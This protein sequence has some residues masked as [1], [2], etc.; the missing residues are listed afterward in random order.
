MTADSEPRQTVAEASD[1][2]RGASPTPSV[3]LSYARVD[4]EDGFVKSVY[5]LLKE[6][7]FNVWWDKACM[8]SRALTFL[9]EIAEA[10]GAADRL[11]LIV[12]PNA[13]SSE[14]VRAEWQYAL[15]ADKVVTPVLRAG[16]FDLLPAELR[17]THCEDVRA[18][19][20]PNEALSAILRLA[21]DPAPRL[22]R[23]FAV[24]VPPAHY[25]P[26]PADFAR[27]AERLM[28]DV[29]EQLAVP[30]EKRAFLIHGMGGVGKSV[31][32]A[33]VA[34]STATR[35]VFSDDVVW[36]AAGPDSGTLQI[37]QQTGSAAG[38]DIRQ[39]AN[40]DAA[41]E[42]LRKRLER[43]AV[44]I[45]LDNIWSKAPV[46]AIREALG[47]RCR[48]IVTTREPGLAVLG[49]PAVDVSPFS[50]EEAVA[51][52]EERARADNL[53]L[54]PAIAEV[55]KECG[56]LPFALTLAGAMA[57]STSWETLA[58]RLRAADLSFMEAN[59]PGYPYTNLLR[60]MQV[61]VDWLGSSDDPDRRA[62]LARYF[63]IAAFR[64][65]S[66]VPEAALATLWR[67]RGGIDAAVSGRMLTI[68]SRYGLVRTEGQSPRRLVRV[69]DL[70]Q[71]YL[72]ARVK[73][74]LAE[75]AAILDAYA[76]MDAAAP[77]VARDD[78]YYLDNVFH[79]LEKAEQ[80]DRMHKVLTSNAADGR[81][82]WWCTR[83]AHGQA[84]GFVAD[85][86]RGWEHA[87]RSTLESGAPD[88]EAVV[89]AAQYALMI[90]SARV[91]VSDVPVGFVGR[92]L[93]EKIW[94]GE[95]AMAV[96]EWVARGQ[97]VL[98]A[99]VTVLPYLPS[100]RKQDAIE[101]GLRMARD[102]VE[103]PDRAGSLL[104]MAPFLDDKQRGQVV[105][106]ALELIGDGASYHFY[107]QAH[108]VA[109]E[110]KELLERAIAAAQSAGDGF[111]RKMA[112]I[113]LA[114]VV[115]EDRIGDLLILAYGA[116]TPE[117]QA[118]VLLEL[119]ARLPEQRRE[120]IAKQAFAL[121][122][123]GEDFK[124]AGVTAVKERARAV[125]LLP[126]RERGR[127][128][129]GIIN[130]LERLKW[131][132]YRL[133]ALADIVPFLDGTQRTEAE[134]L[135]YELSG[136]L[137]GSDIADFLGES[138]RGAWLAKEVP[139][140]FQP[141]VS[142]LLK[143][144]RKEDKAYTRTSALSAL[145]PFVD[146]AQVRALFEEEER[147][148][149][150]INDI[151]GRANCV[152]ALARTLAPEAREAA[153]E[154]LLREIV[155]G[156]SLKLSGRELAALAPVAAASQLEAMAAALERVDGFSRGY[157]AAALLAVSACLGLWRRA[158]EFQAQVSSA[159]YLRLALKQFP[160]KVPAD[161]AHRLVL[162]AIHTGD[163]EIAGA[164]IAFLYPHL[165][166]EDREAAIKVALQ[167]AEALDNR[168]YRY[169]LL[170][171]LLPV[172]PGE[173]LEAAAA[174]IPKE[175]EQHVM[176][177]ENVLVALSVRHAEC[178][179]LREAIAAAS[180]CSYACAHCQA[181]TRM[182][183]HFAPAE[184]DRL[185][186][187][188][189]TSADKESAGTRVEL[190]ADIARLRPEP[191]RSR[192]IGKALALARGIDKGLGAT[193]AEDCRARALCRILPLLEGHQRT[194]ATMEAWRN[195]AK[196][197]AF[198]GISTLEALAPFIAE[199]EP[200]QTAL[201]WRADLEEATQERR[202][203]LDELRALAVVVARLS[204]EAG[205]SAVIDAVHRSARW[206]P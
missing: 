81:N 127:A 147:R 5:G 123:D 46:E 139:E 122:R 50:E 170:E 112:V 12:S 137:A 184:A 164:A 172:L 131:G 71:D 185:L 97:R 195:A 44:L 113:A 31:L 67:A 25:R 15:V 75:H 80:S 26:R 73:D 135:A 179:Q 84:L 109:P 151:E 18:E 70:Q 133:A 20:D 125:R 85:V 34:R 114:S 35:R 22:G 194:N 94:T 152:A 200:A 7:G 129:I 88:K 106:E 68:L 167:A 98:G 21:K 148:S 36:V 193:S 157:A 93:A 57:E 1:S 206:W 143:V 104:R 192:L 38:D 3:F 100:E 150:R 69:H 9:H 61:S 19:R 141:L 176:E 11:L 32:A 142:E 105:D 166:A 156:D 189:E 177:R 24:P 190:L 175:E 83:T 28:L 171:D 188:A 65:E 10:I 77:F 39:Y 124:A 16:G 8:P 43:S 110:R 40:E 149:Q 63:E 162:K 145:L 82:A 37:L 180:R 153:I 51:Y 155:E 128:A 201:R 14:Y 107:L 64:W 120:A 89:R 53:P 132:K 196:S 99:L 56:F 74:P 47:P 198:S 41:K 138:G 116:G 197:G 23:A 118:E 160:A 154:P 2:A 144:A 29:P 33:A 136:E 182:S 4:D 17:G 55:A 199:L 191:H 108:Q 86:R 178:G 30:P 203:V 181:Y 130:D 205:A 52:L 103:P 78:G 146:P 159:Y 91:A 165:P 62:A 6:G 115:P 121:L 60:A 161:A 163:P 173:R 27:I 183:K 54:S 92:L 76:H 111:S 66:G 58:E 158:V 96:L 134:A 169:E 101:D 13:V 117:D 174:L 79:H 49:T 140:F 102:Q 168:H 45:V 119:A 204:G 95:Q 126:P 42:L 187:R 87:W 72:W 48:L 186:D 202:H 59:I 90:G